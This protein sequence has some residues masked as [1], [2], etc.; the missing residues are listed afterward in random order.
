M[1]IG[2]FG[3]VPYISPRNPR[4]FPQP[5]R[6]YDPQLGM[7]SM[8]AGLR[9]FEIADDLGFDAVSVAEHHFASR[10]LTPDPTLFA[11]A[12]TQ[13]VRNAKIAILG[14]LLPMLDPVRV[15]EQFA[16][17][18]TL[19]HGRLLPG[20][21]RGTPNELMVY[22]SNPKE[23]RGRYEEAVR[24]IQKCW[25]EPEPFGWE[26]IYYRYR[27]IA[28]WPRPVQQPTPPLLVSGNSPQSAQFAG[29]HHLDMGFSMGNLT[30][31][32]TNIGHYKAAA[33]QAG[34]T[35]SPDNLLTRYVIYVGQSDEKA[36]EEFGRNQQDNPL[37]PRQL[38]YIQAMWTAGRG[39]TIA[40]DAALKPAA[41][42]VGGFPIM[43]GSPDTLLRKMHQ[44][45]E[46]T[47]VGR[48]DLIFTGDR[49]P[50]EMGLASLKLFAK[51]MLP[52]LHKLDARPFLDRIE[53]S[54]AGDASASEPAQAPAARA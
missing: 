54:P 49:L 20:V 38:A 16:M 40:P 23:S 5:P 47:G 24:L 31:K 33:R 18:D 29:K 53:P 26:G 39:V 44:I 27:S 2:V 21:F 48:F 36:H 45:V 13:R 28:V 22:H 52:T 46:T 9:V 1:Q 19:S 15:A 35:P 11:A 12:M 43:Y 7:R 3:P 10:Q 34:W 4:G 51:E 37:D 42:T 32:A 14:V 50:Q 25:T 17:L 6:H 41:P 30:A 8:D